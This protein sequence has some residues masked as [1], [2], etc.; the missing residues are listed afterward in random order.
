MRALRRAVAWST[1][2]SMLCAVLPVTA[3]AQADAAASTVLFDEARELSKQGKWKEACLKFEDSQ[4]L[5]PTVNTQYWLADCF[6]HEGR[7]ATAWALFGAVVSQAKAKGESA[8][9]QKAS[10]RRD[11]LAGR[12]TRVVVKVSTPDLPGL[13]VKRGETAI[14]KGSWGAALPI[15]P[16]KYSFEASA[17]GKNAWKEERSIEGEGKTI[18]VVVPAL[19]PAPADAAPP[20]ATGPIAPP[21]T[22]PATAAPTTPSSAPAPSDKRS[23]GSSQR[24]IG[25]VAGAAGIVLAGVGTVFWFS[26]KS[27]YESA[28]TNC[29]LGANHDRCSAADDAAQESAISRWSTGKLL[30]GIG[31]VVAIGGAV[32]YFTSPTG[33]EKKSAL[34]TPRISLGI[35]TVSLSGT[36]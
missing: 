24:T 22:A 30:A 15:D 1:L 8:K 16:G 12:L 4:N 13:V 6:E 26:G 35:G 36:F 33:E 19:E 25:L 10:G 11:A 32:V 17:P 7:T 14:G 23:D 27:S 3:F 2:S 5:A 29:T 28:T 18:E 20:V 21:T 9:E 34:T 31:A